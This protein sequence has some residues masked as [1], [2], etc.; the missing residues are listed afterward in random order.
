M[1]LVRA[2]V[3]LSEGVAQR[4]IDSFVVR[5][6]RVLMV[7]ESDG[8]WVWVGICCGEGGVS[9]AWRAAVCNAA[10]PFSV[11]ASTTS[12]SIPFSL[13]D[14]R[15][16]CSRV[17]HRGVLARAEGGGEREARRVREGREERR[18]REARC[19]KGR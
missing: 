14:S 7:S 17:M 16:T 12:E 6:W 13:A 1:R 10:V 15:I 8:L 3:R 4:D 11:V 2:A 5:V 9:S 19:V 18:G